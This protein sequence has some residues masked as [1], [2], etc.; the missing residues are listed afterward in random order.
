MR[1]KPSVW[2]YLFFKDPQVAAIYLGVRDLG[3]AARE[4]RW[5]KHELPESKLNYACSLRSRGYPLQYILGSQPFGPLNIKCTPDV[6]IPRWETEEW[7]FALARLLHEQKKYNISALDLG[8]GT[9]CVALALS[10]GLKDSTIIGID[11]SD[12][13]LK[14]FE[15]NAK[16][17]RSFIVQNN[18]EL[19]PLKFD[20]L[21]GRPNLVDSLSSIESRKVRGVEKYN[22]LS[23]VKFPKID[24]IV[25]NPP[26]ISHNTFIKETQRHVRKYEPKLALLGD[27][28]YYNAIIKIAAQLHVP[29]IVCEVGNQLQIDYSLELGRKMGYSGIS[30]NDSARKPRLFAMWNDLKWSFLTKLKDSTALGE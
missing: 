23:S 2:N 28:E 14:V 17:N 7:S 24:L 6:L 27:L 30:V 1:V 18:N 3:H 29:A 21:K 25:S 9:G 4:L 10:T 11:I 12:T 5:M 8:T 19:K 13:A 16:R 22:S 20:I 26:Y 15:Q